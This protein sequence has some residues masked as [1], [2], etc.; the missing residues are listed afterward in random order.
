MSTILSDVQL[1]VDESS[2]PV[3]WVIDQLYDAIN[4]AQMEVWMN[5]REWQQI[6]TN[7]VLSSGNDIIPLPATTIMVPQ[8]IIYNNVKVFPTT[9]A[10][11]QDW[12]NNW[13]STAPGRTNWYLLWDWQH[14]RL[15]PRSDSNYTFTVFGVPW[16]TEVGDGNVDIVNVDPLVRRAIVMR[17][18]AKLLETTQ[19]EMADAK[20]MEAEEFEKRYARQQRN[21]F[22]DNI[23]RLRPKTTQDLAN[24]GDIR[25]GRLFM[26][27]ED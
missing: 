19:P 27:T 10:M 7:I 6:S 26:G 18:A 14:I 8:F 24:Q 21:T 13:K 15:F 17:A 20:M 1:Q 23:L 3:F 11:L 5:L 12:Q 22:G 2:G 25:V 16:P 4:A 9:L